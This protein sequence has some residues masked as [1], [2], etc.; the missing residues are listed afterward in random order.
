[1]SF[2][3]LRRTLSVSSVFVRFLTPLLSTMRPKGK[4]G[5]KSEK[6]PSES[7]DVEPKPK[8]KK[9]ETAEPSINSDVTEAELD[10][11]QDVTSRDGKKSN[12]KITS[13]NVNGLR[14]WLKN[15]SKS[16]VSKED[17][18][19]FCIQETKCALADIPKEAKLAGYHCYWNSAEQ[20]GYSGVGLCSK[21]EPIKVS[22][23]MGNKEHDKEGRVITAEYEDF[24][25]VTSY[26]PNSGRGLPRLGYRQQWNKDFLSYLKKLDEIKPVILCG[27][28]NVAH[29]DI[30]LANPKTNTRTAGFTKEER[31]DFT[32][33]LGEGFKDTFRELY[34]DKKSAY[35]FWSYMGG[36]R[37]K[38]VGWRLDYFVVSDRLVP[39]VC[40]SIIRSRVMGSDHCPLSLLLSI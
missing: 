8:R 6:R 28:L 39:K 23:G 29:K 32:T 17:P 34:P 33:L 37:A 9:K 2:V 21:K 4:G 14:A 16:F 24:H 18:D 38:N 12:F 25:L 35:T 31:A 40:D 1:M 3:C 22:Y 20:K 15:N 19:V 5:K 7:E 13:W 10:T 30:D 36:A 26:V 27:D 11:S